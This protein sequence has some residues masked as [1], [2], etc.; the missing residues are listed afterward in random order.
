M[1]K[2]FALRGGDRLEVL[3]D[4]DL[5]VPSRSIA[6]L[7]GRS[8][9]GMSMLL[10]II[11]GITDQDTGRVFIDGAGLAPGRRAAVG[12]LFHDDRHLLLSTVLRHVALLLEPLRRLEREWLY[13]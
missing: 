5:T 2:S 6:A 8:G 1:S 10:H 13:L 11:A 4:I 3:R 7:L 9:C 12:Y